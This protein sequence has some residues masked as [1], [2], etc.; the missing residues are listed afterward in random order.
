MNSRPLSF[1]EYKSIYSKV[2]RAT[3][4][5]VIKDND[6]ILLTLRTLPSW[7][8]QWHLPGGTILY[9]E[10]I[11]DAVERIAKEE[12]GVKVKFLKLLGYI[13]YDNEEKEAG[14]GTTVDLGV[15]CEPLENNFT[16]NGDASAIHIFK[17]LPT[18]IIL[19]QANFLKE[20]V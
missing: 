11:K 16:L 9:K 7:N 14:F 17:E 19:E 20:H 3:V 18:N 4:S 1:E 5:L 6:G 13:E 8:N 2:P 10:K 12:I 15:L